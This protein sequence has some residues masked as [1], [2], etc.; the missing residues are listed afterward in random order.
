MTITRHAC[1]KY[2][3]LISILTFT[4]KIW[5]NKSRLNTLRIW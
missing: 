5:A 2:D 1:L 4:T 3:P